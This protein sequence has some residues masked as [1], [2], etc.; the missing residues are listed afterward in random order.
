MTVEDLCA[1]FPEIPPDL[2][3][4]P[5]LARLADACGDLLRVARKPTAC[6]QEHDLANHYYLKLIGPLS[7]YGYGLTSVEKLRDQIQALLDRQESDPAGFAA[8]LVPADAAARE[9]KGPGCE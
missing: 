1:R 5:L 7:V 6:S 4:E 8:S 9:V 2:R 3:G